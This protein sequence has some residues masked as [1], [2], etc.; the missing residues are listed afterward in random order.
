MNKKMLD[1]KPNRLASCATLLCASL[2]SVSGAYAQTQ[3]DQ[4]QVSSVAP[5]EFSELVVTSPKPQTDGTGSYTSPAVTVSGK[6]P[7]ALKEIPNSVS[8][9]TRQ[10]MDDMNLVTTWDA[11]TQITGVQAVANDSMQGQYYARGSSLNVQYDGVPSLYPLNGNQQ[12]DLAIYDR[13]EVQ[14]GPSGVLQGSG[15]FGGTV[16][17]VKKRPTDTFAASVLTTVGSWN[18]K[19]VEADI[20][21]PLNEDKSVRG[22]FVASAL[23]KEWFV[24]RYT[25][26]KQLVYGVLEADLTRDTTARV[27]LARQHDASPGYSGLPTYTNGQLLSVDRSFNPSP[28][29][30]RST[31]DIT[32]LSADLE[33]RF[34]NQWVGK[35]RV[36][37]R[38]ADY[39]LKDGYLRSG[40]DP[41]TNTGN[42]TRREMDYSYGSND[43][44]VNLS[45]PFSWL[46]RQHS[47]LLGANYSSYNSTGQ[48]VNRNQ[49][50]TL[51]VSNVLFTDPPAVPEAFVAYKSGS[52]DLTTQKGVYGQARL[53]VTDPLTL[54]LGGRFSD[55][56]NK[57]RSVA[58]S[59][60]TAWTQGA[61]E[62]S[63]FTPYAG[64][65]Y[66]LND[67]QSLYASYA[68]IFVPQTVKKADGSVLDPRVGKQLE[69]GVKGEYF[70]GKLN[71]L[72]AVFD[73]KEV[74][75]SYSDPANPG[76]Y[77]PLGEVQS[78]GWEAE[79]SGSPLPG[80]N[81]SAGYTYLNTRQAVTST[82]AS[83]GQPISYWYPVH[84]LKLWSHYR[85]G[86]GALAGFHVGFGMNGQSKTASGTSTSTVAARE[87][88]AYAV[89]AAQVGYQF[90]KKLSATFTVN[91]LFDKTYFTRVQGTNTYM[92]YG[93]PRNVML[94]V[95]ASF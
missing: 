87:Q 36:S 31:W 77:L 51:D 80:L 56:S 3:T 30:N 28:A 81:L 11:F 38:E 20:S 83:V 74:N 26:K 33:H 52:E 13:V 32:E 39:Y 27:S 92:S 42:Y 79:V 85:F 70:D 95:R 12:F 17:L 69:L 16:N 21:G 66:D 24:N 48:L 75:R 40:I 25:D 10:Q 2:A 53:S 73:I 34:D 76:F 86:A 58:P 68:D 47:L 91:N 94:A 5:T 6:T 61:K 65:V 78:N 88:G 43:L 49:D 4:A 22:R 50:A 1:A 64:V 45:G 72:L 59:V 55:Y 82:A 18:N 7:L 67:K 29:W 19:R 8:V 37:R 35:A 14:R 60:P 71:T 15:S 84:T 54:V 93:E 62:S 89:Y 63:Q 23:D 46:G 44:D 90:S 41:V 57:S 9:L